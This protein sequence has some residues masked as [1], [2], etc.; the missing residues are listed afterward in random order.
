M[1]YLSALL[2]ALPSVAVAQ[3]LVYAAEPC[4]ATTA[5]AS[6][7]PTTTFGLAVDPSAQRARVGDVATFEILVRSAREQNVSLAWTH[8]GDAEISGEVSPSTLVVA[9]GAPGR[10]TLLVKAASSGSA[11]IEVVAKGP[12]GERHAAK[13]ELRVL[14]PPETKPAEEPRASVEERLRALEERVRALEERERDLREIVH[15]QEETI[16]KLLRDPRP[17]AETGEMPDRAYALMERAA[18]LLPVEG[19]RLM[20]RYARI[21]VMMETD[22]NG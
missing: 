11:V 20:G 6:C 12:D 18:S 3:E 14:A 22:A 17:V 4:P 15:R 9:P 10:A 21:L 19:N 1:L 16:R 7:A 13:A 8:R 2:L 5:S